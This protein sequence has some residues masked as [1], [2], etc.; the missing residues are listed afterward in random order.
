MSRGAIFLFGHHP[1]VFIDKSK[2]A[3]KERFAYPTLV[4]KYHWWVQDAVL[5]YSEHDHSRHKCR[6]HG[7]SYSTKVR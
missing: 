5:K 7:E 2:R 6:L 4:H 1:V 3:D